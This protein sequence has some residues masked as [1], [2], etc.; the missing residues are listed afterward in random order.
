MR[1]SLAAKSATFP[2]GFERRF[3]PGVDIEN[4]VELRYL[5]HTQYLLVHASQLHLTPRL[6]D[7]RIGPRQLTDAGTIDKFDLGQIEYELFR[8]IASDDVNQVAEFS[9]ALGRGEPTHRLDHDD[10]ADLSLTQLKSQ[11]RLI[12]RGRLIRPPSPEYPVSV[13]R[14]ALASPPD[15]NPAANPALSRS[16]CQ[17]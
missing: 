14:C 8:P 7:D 10:A 3:V 4:P 6:P 5:E 12:P 15:A 13:R 2:K 1:E 17:N 9:V 11:G 16:G